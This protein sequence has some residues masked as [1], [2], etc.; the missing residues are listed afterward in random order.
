[1]IGTTTEEETIIENVLHYGYYPDGGQTKLPAGIEQA[2]ARP[3]FKRT[4]T[5]LIQDGIDALKRS[6]D[7]LVSRTPDEATH[8]LPLS[9]GLDSRLILA[10][11][12]DHPNIR[13]AQIQT[14]TFGTPGTWDF[15]IGQRVANEVGVQN[16][17]INLT[18]SEFDWSWKAI[19]EYARSCRPNKFLEGYINSQVPKR[20]DGERVFWSGFMGDPTAGAHQPKDPTNSW[21]TACEKFASWNKEPNERLAPPKYDPTTILP[22]EPFLDSARLSYEEQLDFAVRQ[23]YFIRPVV[24]PSTHHYLTPFLQDEWL[25]FA[26][27]LPSEYRSE[28]RLFSELMQEAHPQLFSLPTDARYGLPLSVPNWRMQIN[29]VGY[30]LVEKITS[31]FG[32]N[33]TLPWTNYLKFETAYRRRACFR[34]LAKNAVEYFE[35]R[36]IADYL[37]GRQI[38]ECHQTGKNYAAELNILISLA[39]YLQTH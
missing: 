20:T 11:L 37:D 33:Y 14:V 19:A 17:A 29:R 28:R 10:E 6:F 23:Q 3:E 32:V 2:T 36:D 12:Y 30:H 16:I 26:F 4:K 24:Q 13:P 5:D 8:V 1:M 9:G 31:L 25:S 35:S 21:E 38:W 7:E 22:D 34:T 27:R 15:E 18:A 39:L